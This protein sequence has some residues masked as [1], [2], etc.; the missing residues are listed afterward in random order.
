MLA[1]ISTISSRSKAGQTE[2]NSSE[3]MLS[4]AEI[5][6]F[7]DQS[8][9]IMMSLSWIPVTW[10]LILT[11]WITFKIDEKPTTKSH[12]T[13]QTKQK[14]QE[15][16]FMELEIT[17]ILCVCVCEVTQSCPT[18]CDPMDIRFLHPWD[19]LGKSTGVGCHFLLWRFFPTQGLNPGLQHCRQMLYRLSHQGSP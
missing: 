10:Q 17:V 2:N 9:Q 7:Q 1:E 13:K 12:K 8:N 11:H 5:R 18:L 16:I 15:T 14:H 19:F 6:F 4:K 3:E